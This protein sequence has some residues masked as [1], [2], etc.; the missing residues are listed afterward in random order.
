MVDYNNEATI[1]TPASD[2]IRVAILER[3]SYFIDALEAYHKIKSQGI[4]TNTSIL[5]SRLLALFLELQPAIERHKATEHYEQL[6]DRIRSNEYEDLYEAFLVINRWLDQTKL[7]RIDNI[8][9]YDRTRVEE[10]N[11]I[12]GL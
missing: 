2:I 4:E 11:K 1:G 3:R 8:Q 5:K 12:S 6:I 9:T 7:I 10:E